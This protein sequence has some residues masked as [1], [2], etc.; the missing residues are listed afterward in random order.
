MN[1]TPR[2]FIHRDVNGFGFHHAYDLLGVV[3]ALGF[4]DDA[5]SDR[6]RA[7]LERAR[8]KAHEI[9]NEY[10]GNE[11]DA[12]HGNGYEQLVGVLARLNA[13]RLIKMSKNDAAKNRTAWIG[14]A[15]QH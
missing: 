6:S 1:R 2:L 4:D 5:D 14:V 13:A 11:F 8:V 9:A 12:A 10:G 7:N 15:R 3:V